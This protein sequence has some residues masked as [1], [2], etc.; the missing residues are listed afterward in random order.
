[1][2]A[3][4]IDAPWLHTKPCRTACVSLLVVVLLSLVPLADAS[5]VD[6]TWVPGLWDNGDGDDIV[7]L[8]MGTDAPP[9]PIGSFVVWS[10][11]IVH[12]VPEPETSVPDCRDRP[13]SERAPPVI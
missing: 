12:V 5:P 2:T 4:R 10:R 3:P 7:L 8:I 1:M 6:P 11:I 9:V 13:A